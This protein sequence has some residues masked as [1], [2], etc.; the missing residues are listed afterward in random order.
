MVENLPLEDVIATHFSILAWR[1]S[2]PEES[3]GPQRVGHN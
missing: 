2:R 1:I 3:G